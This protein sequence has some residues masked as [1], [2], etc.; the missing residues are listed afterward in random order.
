MQMKK[1]SKLCNEFTKIKMCLLT[2]HYYSASYALRPGWGSP[3]QH[4]LALGTKLI[5]GIGIDLTFNY[6]LL[7]PKILVR[8]SN[9]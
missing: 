9:N 4:K 6:L 8:T 3:L 5:G 2:R 1:M 7:L